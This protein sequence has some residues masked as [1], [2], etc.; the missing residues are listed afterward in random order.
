[1]FSW[2]RMTGARIRGW[3]SRRRVEEDFSRELDEHIA[4]LT[5]ENILRGMTREEARR[6]ARLRLGGMTQLQEM[7]RELHGWAALENFLDRKSVV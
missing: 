7:H 5:E 2:L 1:M 3:V 6:A 4:L